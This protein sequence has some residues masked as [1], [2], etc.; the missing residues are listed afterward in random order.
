M[1]HVQAKSFI[2]AF[3]FL[4]QGCTLARVYS[5]VYAS[6][7]ILFLGV[8]FWFPMTLVGPPGCMMLLLVKP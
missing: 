5:G 7:P 2:L 3:Y 8:G 1:A 4:P 6:V